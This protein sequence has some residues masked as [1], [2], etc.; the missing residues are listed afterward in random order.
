[1]NTAAVDA[2]LRKAA[3]LVGTGPFSRRLAA[4]AGHGYGQKRTTYL[5]DDVVAFK[6]WG[7][8]CP[9][10]TPE[11][12]N[13]WVFVEGKHEPQPWRLTQPAPRPGDGPTAAVQSSAG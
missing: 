1:M 12:G 6:Q 2:I 5:E 11:S 10:T 3:D 4:V 7:E 13:S 8:Y 9:V